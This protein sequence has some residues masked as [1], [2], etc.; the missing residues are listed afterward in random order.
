[1]KKSNLLTRTVTGVLFVAVLIGVPF[2]G[3]DAFRVLFLIIA[4]L[5]VA[6]LV[7]LVRASGAAKLD[8]LSL[9]L[10]TVAV[11]VTVAIMAMGLDATIPACVTVLLFIL[12]FIAQLYRKVEHPVNELAYTVFVQ[13]Y[14]VVPFAMAQFLAFHVDASGYVTYSPLL[15]LAMFGFIWANDDNIKV[16]RDNIKV[17]DIVCWQLNNGGLIQLGWTGPQ[18]SNCEISRIDILHAE[19]NRDES[20]RGVISLVGNK[21]HT[22]GAYGWT[23]N[24]IV[25][26]VVTETPVS[27]LF[28]F[29]PD[30]YT[31]YDIDGLVMKDWT[32]LYDRSLGFHNYMKGTS[33]EHKFK[34]IVFDNVTIDG[35]KMT[36]DNW[37]EE[38]NFIVENAET[39]EFK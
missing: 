27:V 30:P 34:G 14:A 2:L 8:T 18:S 7:K 6:E 29:Q 13:A 19:W 22:D 25:E 9:S 23:K 11:F 35:V 21:Y 28:N 4:C 15:P 31:D 39:P 37:M 20:N 32:L 33:P 10:L 38:A 3:A 12:V 16:Y 17:H 1:M 24:W 5:T 26:D 36:A